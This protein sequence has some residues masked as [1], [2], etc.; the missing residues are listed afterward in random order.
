MS[1]ALLDEA[2]SNF[3]SGRIAEAARLCAEVLKADPCSAGSLHLLGLIASH[4]H[5]FETAEQFIEKAIQLDSKIPGYFNDLGIIR[6]KLQ[7]PDEQSLSCYQ[8]ALR[9]NPDFI[10]AQHNIANIWRERGELD[11]AI[12]GYKQVLRLSKEHVPARY[13]LGLCLLA[14]DFEEIALQEF[15]AVLSINPD[16][17][18]AHRSLGYLLRK[19]KQFE[20]AF[21]HFRRVMELDACNGEV[22]SIAGALLVDL[23]KDVEAESCFRQAAALN[24][25]SIEALT[26]LGKILR[27]LGKFAEAVE[28]FDQ[29]LRLAPDS[30]AGLNELGIAFSHQDKYVESLSCFQRALQLSPERAET[31]CNL[32]HLYL[33]MRCFSEAIGHL[34][35]ALA[36][37]PDFAMAWNNLAGALQGEALASGDEQGLEEAEQCYRRALENTPEAPDIHVNLALLSLVR[38]RFEAGWREYNWRLKAKKSPRRFPCP[39]WQGESFEGKTILLHAEQGMGDT[40]QFVRFA[41]KVKQRGGAVVLLCQKALRPL[42]VGSAGIDMLL[43]EDQALP[44]FDLHAPLLSL[45]EIF[46]VS[47]ESIP[48]ETPYLFPDP[49]RVAHWKSRLA[50]YQGFKVGIVWQGNAGHSGDRWRSIPLSCFEPLIKISGLHVFSLQTGF[51]QE[52]IAQTAENWGLTELDLPFAEK[53]AAMMSLDLVIACDTAVGHLAGA[54]GRTVWVAIPAVP[55]WRWLTG[56]QDTPWYPT[57]R[58]FRQHRSEGW[59][60]VLKNIA[61]ALP[62][63]QLSDCN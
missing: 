26:D 13:G 41:S 19:R 31:L 59:S 16:Y 25:D 43:D 32:G 58:L 57:M 28:C 23:D 39:L 50:N 49:D 20:Q 56:R 38:G 9:I 53:A 52:Q 51:G 63:L 8:E 61:H 30:L 40:I 60:E 22:F 18:P 44:G 42:L 21:V 48:N 37:K 17:L 4:T 24:P 3:L 11:S 47:L 62:E 35:R 6:R 10:E 2:L 33:R 15:R 46:G 36:L 14:Q 5:Q 27:T 55:D 45:P 1:S 12:N 29:V 34:Q 54:L 7:Q